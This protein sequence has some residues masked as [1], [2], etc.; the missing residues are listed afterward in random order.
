MNSTGGGNSNL[1]DG[2]DGLQTYFNANGNILIRY[3]NDNQMY[4]MDPYEF[5][6]NTLPNFA[7]SSFEHGMIISIGND[8][9]MGGTLFPYNYSTIPKPSLPQPSTPKC[10]YD[11]TTNVYTFTNTFN[12]VKNSL[13]YKFSFLYTYKYPKPYI[14]VSYTVDIPTGNTEVVKFA[15]GWDAKLAGS[16]SSPH[17][18]IDNAKNTIVGTR[19]STNGFQAMIYKSGTKWSGYYGAEASELKLYLSTEYGNFMELNTKKI[20]YQTVDSSMGMSVNF[21]STPGTQTTSNLISFQCNAPSAAPEASILTPAATSTTNGNASSNPV[22]PPTST[23]TAT[24]IEPNKVITVAQSAFPTTDTDGDGIKDVQLEF[25]NTTTKNSYTASY[26]NSTV[27]LPPGTYTVYFFDTVNGCI[28]PVRTITITTPTCNSDLSIVKTI[29]TDAN[30]TVQAGKTYTITYTAKNN[31]TSDNGGVV[32]SDI[33]P[34]GFTV[35]GSTAPT[36]TTYSNGK[37]T[38]GGI[39]NGDTKVLT[40]TVTTTGKSTVMSTATITGSA[41]DSNTANNSSNPTIVL[42]SDFDGDGISDLTDLDSD[43]DGIL[44][45]VE[46]YCDQNTPPNGTWPVKNSSVSFANQPTLTKQLLFWDWSNVE[47]S[48]TNPTAT[49]TVVHNGVTYTATISNFTTNVVPQIAGNK[50]S[51]IGADIPNWNNTAYNQFIGH[52]YNV[53]NDTFKETLFMSSNGTGTSKFNIDVTAVKDGK[54][55]P[56]ELVVFDSESTNTNVES[57][58]FK[59]NSSN[60]KLVEKTGAGSMSAQISG[61]TNIIG[62]NTNTIMYNNTQDSN[63]NA[64]FSTSG[65]NPIIETTV[66][67]ANNSMEG[68]GFAV[69]LYCDTDDDGIPSFLDTDSDGDGCADALEGSELVQTSQIH[70]LSLPSTDPNYAYR[71]QIKVIYDGKTAG[72]P[73]G[74]VST[75]INA[76]GVPQLVNNAGNNLNSTTN[77][78]NLAGILDNVD[79]TADVGQANVSASNSAVTSQACKSCY[80]PS[81]TTGTSIPTNIGISTIGKDSNW[82]QNRIGGFMAIESKTKGLVVTRMSTVQIT[83]I[84]NPEVGMVAFDTT[85]DC[86]KVYT[87]NNL[88][89]LGWYCMENKSC[90]DQL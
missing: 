45:S 35:T 29:N 70:A 34:N 64:I 5:T 37:W 39:S 28:S 69:R 78:S 81:N 61:V 22:V 65:L 8:F 56:V 27:T 41:T 23:Y 82:P 55:Y 32:V 60:F 19:N 12:I 16:D 49:K 53:N 77:P 48:S 88:G 62:E 44:N 9:Y 30:N 6:T 79:G 40:V 52:Y 76:L 18:A 21:G 17:F 25:E 42:F 85:V 3:K 54:S 36:G 26:E 90:E 46:M 63:V 11:A 74:I 87:R 58:T 71:G 84:A 15:H 4:G 2:S 50:A 83:A 10:T 89:V 7:S 47:I 67:T 57:L 31:G 66:Y 24:C 59:T 73:A 80:K 38:I 1:K 68:V 20:S 13:T 72:T 33:I 86:L 75:S 51:F 43:N 14:N